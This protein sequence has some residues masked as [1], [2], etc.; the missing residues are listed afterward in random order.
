M[1]EQKVFNTTDDAIKE[2]EVERR[3]I[4]IKFGWK[5]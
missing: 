2:D 5:G 4:R 1:L 3:D